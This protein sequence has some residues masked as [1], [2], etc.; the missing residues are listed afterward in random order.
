MKLVLEKF[1]CKHATTDVGADSPYFVVFAGE[2]GTVGGTDVLPGKVDR[3]Q[4]NFQFA[5]VW[6]DRWDDKIESGMTRTPNLVVKSHGTGKALSIGQNSAV[7]IAMCE[8]DEHVDIT[9]EERGDIAE[10]MCLPWLSNGGGVV[11][12]SGVGLAHKLKQ[13]FR[14]IVNDAQDDDETLGVIVLDPT[15]GP[16]THTFQ[17]TDKKDTGGRYDVT[18]ALRD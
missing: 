12:S 10:Q 7:L 9:R 3:H 15:S 2:P 8:Q 4:L 16:H 18:F 14:E 5:T 1:E 17:F 11:L 13:T 6:K